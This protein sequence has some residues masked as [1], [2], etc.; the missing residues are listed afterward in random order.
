MAI[1]D[2]ALEGV[3]IVGVQ[4]GG[5]TRDGRVCARA[6]TASFPSRLAVDMKTK[7]DASYDEV[8]QLAPAHSGIYSKL[9]SP[10]I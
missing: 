2:A 6:D 10:L 5:D 7:L 4:S 8:V 3:F 1:V 9:L